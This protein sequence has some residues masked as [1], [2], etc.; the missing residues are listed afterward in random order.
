M[1]NS[2]TLA[3]VV[4]APFMT[5]KDRVETLYLA[6]LSRKPSAKELDRSVRFIDNAVK[7]SPATLD[8][9]ARRAVYGNAMADVF[10]VLLNSSE[11]SLNH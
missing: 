6:A 8:E 7:T 11:F 10:W 1:D 3:A 2:E 9:A 5:T 4:D